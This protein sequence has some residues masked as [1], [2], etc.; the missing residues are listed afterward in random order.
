MQSCRLHFQFVH[1][2]HH[3]SSQPDRKQQVRAACG[4]GGDDVTE[5]SCD[6]S[7]AFLPS[8]P[9]SALGGLR[10]FTQKRLQSESLCWMQAQRWAL[11]PRS[12]P[13]ERRSRR[14]AW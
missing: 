3:S 5:T 4:T 2:L 7:A 6:H 11:P 14:G 9:D 8:A 12:G 10:L 1:L 13:A